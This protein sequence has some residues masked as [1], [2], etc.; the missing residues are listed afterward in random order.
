MLQETLN[1]ADDFSSTKNTWVVDVHSKEILAMVFIDQGQT[2]PKK[3]TGP[4][5][6]I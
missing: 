4:K 5:L 6:F 3:G 2:E 1:A